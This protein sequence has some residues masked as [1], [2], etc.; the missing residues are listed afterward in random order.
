MRL[1]YHEKANVPRIIT[2]AIMRSLK[3]LRGFQFALKRVVAVNE[4][5]PRYVCYDD[6]RIIHKF[7][8]NGR[9]RRVYLRDDEHCVRRCDV[10]SLR[11]YEVSCVRGQ[12][13]C[14]ACH[15]PNLFQSKNNVLIII[16]RV[17]RDKIDMSKVLAALNYVCPLCQQ[18]IKPSERQ[19]VDFDRMKC[20][21]CQG[22]FLE[23]NRNKFGVRVS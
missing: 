20:L 23:Q 21:K 5:T 15:S 22:V 3:S 17:P 19:R 8:I 16:L 12:R 10:L 2:T 13:S 6:I 14:S 7:Q 11:S 1:R 18:T 4:R 9:S